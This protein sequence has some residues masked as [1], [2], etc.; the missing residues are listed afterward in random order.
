MPSYKL[1]PTIAIEVPYC[2]NA[3]M[4]YQDVLGMLEIDQDV[5]GTGVS[6][7]NGDVTLYFMDGSEGKVWLRLITY[8]LDGAKEHLEMNGCELS[9]VPDG[10]LVLDPHGTRFYLTA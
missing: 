5:E 8:D 9:P 4:F 7:R 10:Y 6:F 2:E 3:H 1:I